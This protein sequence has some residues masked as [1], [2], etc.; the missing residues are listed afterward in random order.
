MKATRLAMTVLLGALFTISLASVAFG[1]QGWDFVDG[2]LRVDESEVYSALD[3]RVHL[4]ANDKPA[5][6]IDGD[7][8][9]AWLG[10][11]LAP[12]NGQPYSAQFSQVGLKTDKNGIYWFVYAEP[13]VTC[14]QGNHP[15]PYHC[16]GA[17]GELVGLAA[18]H[19]VELVTYGQGFWIVR[20]YEADGYPHNVAKI[21]SSSLRIYEARSTT[22]QG[23]F[24]ADDPYLTAD[25]Y[26][27][28]PQYM[29]GSNGWQD[30]PISFGDNCNSIR[31][32]A[33][34]GPD[35]CPAHYGASPYW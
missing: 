24:E 10:V 7:L 13:G 16:Y 27:W 5:S 4:R 3:Y 9:T 19:Q 6:G 1:Q 34:N 32:Q 22:E 30:W 15:D 28:H 21:W 12:W 17:Y 29:E 31:T 35:P 20:V 23:Y 18:W 14:L 33:I 11:F 26:H 2:D 25:F 8:T